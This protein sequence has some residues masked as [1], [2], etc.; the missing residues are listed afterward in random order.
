MWHAYVDAGFLKIC[1]KFTGEH[2]CQSVIS[3]KLLSNFIEIVLR[4]GCSPVNL[5]H[6]FRTPFPRNTFGWLFLLMRHFHVKFFAKCTASRDGSRTAVTSKMERFVIIVKG[7]K[8]LWVSQQKTDVALKRIH[9][10]ILSSLLLLFI[11]FI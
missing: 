5:L 7:F 4:H 1:S 2:L 9:R 8:P 10:K 11:L 6:I 3:I